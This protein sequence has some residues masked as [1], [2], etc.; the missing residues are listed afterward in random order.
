MAQDK[1]QEQD[2]AVEEDGAALLDA[3][4]KWLQELTVKSQLERWGASDFI[5]YSQKTWLSRLQAAALATAEMRQK[6][7]GGTEGAWEAWS[8][9]WRDGWGAEYETMSRELREQCEVDTSNRFR[10]ARVSAAAKGR[11]VKTPPKCFIGSDDEWNQIRA[12]M[13][14]H[15]APALSL[16]EKQGFQRGYTERFLESALWGD[17]AGLERVQAEAWA[18]ADRREK[19]RGQ[20]DGPMEAW[21]GGY[22]DGWDEECHEVEKE[23]RKRPYPFA[24]SAGARVSLPEDG[25]R[26]DDGVPAWFRG[27]AE[28]WATRSD[29]ELRLTWK[30]GFETGWRTRFYE[31]SDNNKKL[32][33]AAR[34]RAEELA[35]ENAGAG[36][37]WDSWV[38]GWIEGWAEKPQGRN[39]KKYSLAEWRKKCVDEWYQQMREQAEWDESK[40]IFADRDKAFE[41]AKAE[42]KYLKYRF[43]Q[44]YT[45]MWLESVFKDFDGD[46]RQRFLNA[47][48]GILKKA[49]DKASEHRPR[50]YSE[51]DFEAWKK[52]WLNGWKDEEKRV[53]QQMIDELKCRSGLPADSDGISLTT[54][55][56]ADTAEVDND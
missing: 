42:F 26:G 34:A 27:T 28:E 10:R 31:L 30:N 5:D 47:L 33:R 29:A 25:A 16:A 55:A 12:Q 56:L 22:E 40:D 41:V 46:T 11:R 24:S 14:A 6:E 3:K 44:T 7:S 43:Q 53:I 50:D 4:K 35:G 9:G 1:R 17:R 51:S 23:K 19:L 13:R 36:G 18:A 38:H 39:E 15:I 20:S 45:D 48:G 52:L 49:A 8:A 54:P 21:M 2:A 32:A 37:D